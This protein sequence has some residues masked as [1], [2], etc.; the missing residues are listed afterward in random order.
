MIS[1]RWWKCYILNYNFKMKCVSNCY[2]T[3][4]CYQEVIDLSV[5]KGSSISIPCGYSSQFTSDKKYLYELSTSTKYSILDDKLRHVFTVTIRNLTDEDT[6]FLCGVKNRWLMEVSLQ[7]LDAPS[8]YVDQQSITAVLGGSV[9]VTCHYAKRSSFKWCKLGSKCISKSGEMD[10]ME[11][12]IS[13]QWEMANVTLKELKEKH[14]G[15]YFCQNGGFQM[16]VNLTVMRE[17]TTAGEF[18]AEFY[19]WNS[20]R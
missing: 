7:V 3:D 1:N 11:V 10:G 6:C 19:I 8:L 5:Q 15:W 16:P 13:T 2:F 18:G 14:S 12:I 4:I 9:T 20:N 17:I